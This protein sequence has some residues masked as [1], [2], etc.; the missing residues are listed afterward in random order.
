M[1]KYNELSIVDN[2]LIV[3][4]EI[5]NYPWYEEVFLE[6]LYIATKPNPNP[7]KGEVYTFA[8]EGEPLE[9]GNANKRYRLKFYIPNIK[10]DLIY[11]TP[12][13]EGIDTIPAN[14]PCGADVINIGATYNKQSLLLR[15]MGYLKEL[16]DTCNIP[17]GF[18]DFILKQKALDLA[19]S[20]CNFSSAK[21]YYNLLTSSTKS[22]TKGCG[23]YGT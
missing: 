7:D 15:G 23:C 22:T 12:V 13:I 20:T 5:E 9:G 11:I 16:G 18:I 8:E 4:V 2:Y 19:I 10:N 14:S 1:V 3:D 17:R 21:K 6:D